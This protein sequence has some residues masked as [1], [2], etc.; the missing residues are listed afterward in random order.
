MKILRNQLN[1]LIAIAVLAILVLVGCGSFRDYADGNDQQEAGAFSHQAT[2]INTNETNT[3]ETDTNEIII[4]VY[5]HIEL[6]SLIM[7]LA[8]N[9]EYSEELTDYQ[10]KLRPTFEEFAEHPVVEFAQY[11]RGSVG[12]GFDAPM[13]FAIHLEKED[14]QFRLMEGSY[15]WEIDDRWS[16]ESVTKFLELLN[17]FYIDS[18][19][20]EF[21]EANMPYFKEYSQRLANELLSKINFDW[22]YQ[23]G[24]GSENLRS[25]I[26]PS[27]SWGA[28][29]PTQLRKISY[30]ILP[31]GHC[32]SDHLELIIHE[33]A[34]S[35]ANPIAD[36]WYENN[37]EFRRISNDSINPMQLPWYAEG[38][39]MAREY[40]TRAFTIQY[41]VE[42]HEKNIVHL[43]LSEIV[44][45]FL[46]IETIYTKI[47]EHEYI[48]TSGVDII[49]LILGVEYTLG[50]RQHVVIEA[51]YNAFIYL[52]DLGGIE[53]PW[54]ELEQNSM[55]NWFATQPGDVHVLVDRNG[56]RFLEIDLGE[57]PRGV[58][59]G[60]EE[61]TLRKHSFFSLD[62]EDSYTIA[63]ILYQILGEEVEYTIGELPRTYLAGYYGKTDEIVFYYQAVNLL[64]TELTF[65]DFQPNG[66]GNLMNTQQGDMIVVTRDGRR[67]LHIDHGS[68]PQSVE[69]GLEEGELRLYTIFPLDM[70]D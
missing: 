60:L 64:G 14:G 61:G 33:F 38:F 17:D 68:H 56:R 54:E 53:L 10:R 44:G 23:F 21:F 34:H 49:A 5:E 35:F 65:G 15:I 37:E 50:E 41:L 70:F 43:L 11:L 7:R 69:M 22:F 27:G 16:S 13:H 18:N 59:W 20:A 9:H 31:V 30:A 1:K 39:I 48:F 42:N 8:G 57:D 26:R 51:E 67:Y 24:F 63:Q 58:N 3:Y 4:K 40:V 36:A 2:E 55:G 62:D 46:Y 19:F 66:M 12:L 47:T 25:I 28:Y 52:V 45:G 29:G 32:F 6:V